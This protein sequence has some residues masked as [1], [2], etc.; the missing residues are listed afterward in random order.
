MHE[1]RREPR[2]H[3]PAATDQP[4]LEDT[5]TAK[6]VDR[7]GFIKHAAAIGGAAGLGGLCSAELRA[8][9]PERVQ[10]IGEAKGIHPGRVVWVHDPLATGWKGPGHGHLYD[11]QHTSQDRVDAMMSQAV[12]AVTGEATVAKSWDKLFRHFNRSRGKGD[13]GYR[14][15]EKLVVKPNWVGMIFR[16]G[17]V[18]PETYTLIQRQDYMNTSP[19]MIIALVRQLIEVGMHRA[20]SPSATRSPI[21][22]TSTTTFCTTNS[23]KSNTLTTPA[24]S[25]ESRSRRRACRSFGAA[26]RKERRPITCRWASLRRSTWSISLP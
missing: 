20:I 3:S 16:E 5:F 12:C 23:P 8:D 9:E 4:S 10:P 22:S 7:R 17:A 21:W 13:A 24:S 1:P 2:A 25:G 19:Q 15:G 14:R 26:G 18:N 11:S 6:R